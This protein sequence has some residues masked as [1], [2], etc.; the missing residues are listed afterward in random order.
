MPGTVNARKPA[1]RC[2]GESL[3]DELVARTEMSDVRRFPIAWAISATPACAVPREVGE[4]AKEV[5][6]RGS[7]SFPT[8][9]V[10]AVVHLSS[11][12][13]KS[14]FDIFNGDRGRAGVVPDVLADCL[15]EVGV[16]ASRVDCHGQS[17]RS[18]DDTF[19]LCGHR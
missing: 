17:F 1:L 12:R 16:A 8:R 10:E 3:L 5:S 19:V 4:R 15:D 2:V 6:L 11:C 18:P 14:D 7:S 13:Y 9:S